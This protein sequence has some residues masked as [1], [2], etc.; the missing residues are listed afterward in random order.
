[1]PSAIRRVHWRPVLVLS[2]LFCIAL[3][4]RADDTLPA[5]IAP[6]TPPVVTA[7]MEPVVPA[8]VSR[9]P[10]QGA[11][12][13]EGSCVRRDDNGRFIG[14]MDYEHCVFSGRTLSTAHWFDDLFGDWYDNEARM[15][16]RAITELSL[17]EGAGVGTNFRLNASAALPNAQRRLRLVI[18]DESDSVNTTGTGGVVPGQ[19]GDV[20]STQA[21]NGSQASA[22]LRWIPV[23]KAGIK[24][25]FDIGVRGVNPPDLF[26]RL[27]ARKS[28]SLTRNSLARFG[29]TFR[30]GSARQ[31][32]SISQLDLERALD[33]NSV[34]RLSSA[35]EYDQ[36]DHVNGFKW[37]HGVSLSHVLSDTRSL[38]YGF[39]VDGH[40]S[41]N[42]RS[43][44]YGPWLL[45]RSSFKRSWLFYE[46]EPRLVWN[47][48]RNWGSEASIVFR[49]EVQFG[50][51]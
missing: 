15:M 13:G 27:R 31:G 11:L 17:R 40:T 48:E 49:L 43:E 30:Y 32:S 1:M 26:A 14:W 19:T 8:P 10:G 35:Y 51:R 42:W 4:A 9:R 44:S 28:W 2:A 36:T 50:K 3:P 20:T 46:I 12:W 39:A 37:E 7:Q 21:N 22:A 18:T 41:P 23:Q 25:D 45:F 29:Q 24:T 47:R 34:A 5:F 6:M 16:V 38:G 33:E